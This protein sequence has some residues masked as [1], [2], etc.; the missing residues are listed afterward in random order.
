M[1]YKFTKLPMKEE[2]SFQQISDG[3][4]LAF[5]ESIEDT[6]SASGDKMFKLR[7]KVKEHV[8]YD[9]LL[10]EH[11]NKVCREIAHNKMSTMAEL[12]LGTPDN[13]EVNLMDCL[14]KEAYL[15]IKSKPGNDGNLYPRIVAIKRS[16]QE[17]ISLKGKIAH[18]NA[19]KEVSTAEFINDECPF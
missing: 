6:V 19:S 12:M 11:P 5:L 18:P 17:R 10:P 2:A 13:Q 15:M 9:Y 16:P 14:Y 4:H 1:T 3:M 7:W 8:I